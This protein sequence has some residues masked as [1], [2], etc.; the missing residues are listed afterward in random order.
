MTSLQQS[1]SSIPS[2]YIAGI[3]IGTNT[4][5]LLIARKVKNNFYIAVHSEQS[6]TRLGKRLEEFGE[7][8]NIAI[9]RTIQ[10]LQEWQPL[11]MQYGVTDIV[12][13]A[14]SSTRD[15]K[16]KTYFL[17]RVK[18][19]VG[20][21]IEVLSGEEEARQ[22]LIGINA[23]LPKSSRD[24][25]AIDI[26]GGS[27]EFII[28]KNMLPDVVVSINLGVVRLTEKFFSSNPPSKQTLRKAQDYIFRRLKPLSTKFSHLNES[29]L[30]G[31]AGTIT[32]LAAVNQE[33]KDYDPQRIH[34]HLLSLE[35]IK[36]IKEKCIYKTHEECQK[37]TGI[38]RGRADVIVAGIVLL[39]LI[40][41]TLGFTTIR[42]SEYGLREGII[43]ERVSKTQGEQP[44]LEL[45]KSP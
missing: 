39:E 29:T 7:L 3:D 28:S 14:T 2:E 15:A 36:Q 42:V 32:T 45:F 27:T 8:G 33:M 12:T 11:L 9:D 19:D 20:L 13:V 35:A 25:H 5:R 37:I 31:T 23:G 10:K 17:K 1:S 38:E 43:I 6:I 22:T 24:I 21:D 16:N 44:T 40:M 18:N 26:G 41:E 34:G 4:I 30:I